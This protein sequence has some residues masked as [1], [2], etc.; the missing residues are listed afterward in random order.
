MNIHEYQ[1]KAVLK[2]SASRCRAARRCLYG[3]GGRSGREGARRAG[4][5]GEGADPRRRPRQGPVQGGGGRR[6]GRR[7]PRQVGRGGRASTPPRCSAMTLVT[8]DR[9]GRQGGQAALHRGRL[10]TSPASSTSRLLVDRETGRV[11]FVAST[12]GGM[13]IEEV[14]HDTPEKILDLRGRPGDRH[15]AASRPHASP[16]RSAS[17]ATS[18]SRRRAC[19]A[20]STR[21]SPRRT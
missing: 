5:G 20:S 4:L 8:P 2:S 15:H 1:A 14:A 10:R 7:A 3:R 21:P 16:R 13:D 17:R 18:R 6:Q 11:A 12:E 19:S 9:P